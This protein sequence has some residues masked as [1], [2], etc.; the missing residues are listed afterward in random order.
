MKPTR[1]E[2]SVM[3]GG[4]VL[5]GGLWERAAAEVQETGE[6]STELTLALLDAQGGRSIYEDPEYLEELREAL[7]IKIRDHKIVRSFAISQDI[8]PLLGFP[9]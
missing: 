7:A 9:R 1:R 4:A 6:V 5:S 2:F 8:E 3:L